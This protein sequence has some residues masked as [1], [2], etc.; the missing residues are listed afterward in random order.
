MA[1]DET[2]RDD[3]LK[4]NLPKGEFFEEL[5]CR[6]ECEFVGGPYD[7]VVFRLDP[8]QEEMR[9]RDSETNAYHVYRREGFANKFR[10]E[11]REPNG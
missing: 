8:S 10:Y 3:N 5:A 11:G 2:R 7:G 1:H 6:P 9:M 4:D